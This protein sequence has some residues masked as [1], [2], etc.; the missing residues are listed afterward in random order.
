MAVM[1]PPRPSR[2][3]SSGRPGRPPHSPTRPG[4]QLRVRWDRVAILAAILVLVVVLI[5]VLI[6]RALTALRAD[7]ETLPATDP[8]ERANP[9]A[10]TNPPAGDTSWTITDTSPGSS[11]GPKPC[12]APS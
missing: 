5:V 9:A 10:G 6:V 7:G 3:P 1:S 11:T 2:T 4:G 12:P 8:I